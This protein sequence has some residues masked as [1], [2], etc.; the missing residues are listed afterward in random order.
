[1]NFPDAL[2]GAAQLA[3]AGGPLLLTTT[4]VL[5]A[6]SGSALAAAKASITNTH[7]YG[8]SDVVADP[9]VL[10]AAASLGY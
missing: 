9:V 4:S 1:M 10:T 5:P 3:T 2:A 6:A 8:Q 7:F